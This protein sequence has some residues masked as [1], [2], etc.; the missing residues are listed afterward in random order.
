MHATTWARHAVNEKTTR[1]VDATEHSVEKPPHGCLTM[2]FVGC[3]ARMH[4]KSMGL[5]RHACPDMGST[6]R[7]DATEHSLEKPPHGCLT[8]LFVGCYARM[9]HKSMGLLRHACHDMGSTRRQ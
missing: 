7:V 3:Y 9:H 6:R 1:R 8:M 2:L 4:H 5:L